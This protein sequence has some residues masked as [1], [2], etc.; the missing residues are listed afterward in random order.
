VLA[1]MRALAR[2]G[3]RAGIALE[4]NGEVRFEHTWKLAVARA[5]AWRSRQSFS[6]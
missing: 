4:E 3:I 1:V 5:R 6:A 2:P